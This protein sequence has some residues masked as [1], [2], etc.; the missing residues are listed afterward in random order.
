MKIHVFSVIVKNNLKFHLPAF[1][2]FFSEI[3]TVELTLKLSNVITTLLLSPWLLF[4][5]F[6]L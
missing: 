4:S 2:I 1:L 5:S 3:D 6:F